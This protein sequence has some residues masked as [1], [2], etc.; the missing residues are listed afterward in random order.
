MDGIIMT[1]EKFKNEINLEG[2]IKVQ[3]W[4]DEDYPTVYYE[5]H[6]WGDLKEYLN[7]EVAYVFPYKAEHNVA[8]CI[9]LAE[10]IS[11]D[12]P[13][14]LDYYDFIVSSLEEADFSKTN[15]TK[16]MVMH[17]YSLMARISN[18][19]CR[20]INNG[21]ELQWAVD[22]AIEEELGAI[23]PGHI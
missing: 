12:K 3:C 17:N 11:E 8:I 5:G 6:G 10:A 2:Y 20:A 13:E 7:R 22:D 21:C 15:Y 14:L 23:I 9:E 16:E 4:E 19:A 1:L 18:N